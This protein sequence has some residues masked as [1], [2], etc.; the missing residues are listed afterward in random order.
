MKQK[1]KCNS[2]KSTTIEVVYLGKKLC[3]TCW[4]KLCANE[5]QQNDN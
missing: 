4:R 1:I 5:V 3:N 2:C